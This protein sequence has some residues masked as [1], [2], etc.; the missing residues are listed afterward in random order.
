[1]YATAMLQPCYSCDAPHLRL[2][3][4]HATAM[5]RR[6]WAWR[7]L[8]SPT[9][10]LQLLMRAMMPMSLHLRGSPTPAA[11]IRCWQAAWQ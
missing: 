5:L 8:I 7:S 6:T 10:T 9:A 2:A 1:M 11:I 3:Y 4:S